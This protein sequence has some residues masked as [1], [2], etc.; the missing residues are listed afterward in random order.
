MS[1]L[2][3][4][5][6]KVAVVTGG[7][8]GI[9]RMMAEGF[10]QAGARTYITSRKAEE[11]QTSAEELSALGECVALQS[12]L[13]SLEGVRRFAREIR[14]RE[15]RLDILVNNA[16]ATWGE[17][18]EEYQESGWDKVMNINLKSLF[19]LTQQSLPILRASGCPEDPARVINIA[20]ING[21]A[22][23]GMP[24]YAYSASKAA[25]IHL[26][27]HLAADLVRDHINVNGIAPGFFPSKMTKGL[28]E[29]L[30]EKMLRRIPRGRLGEPG[31]IAG[32]A[33]YLSSR[34]SAWMVGQTLVLDGG[35][36]AA[37]G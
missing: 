32:T 23:P 2:F 18:L 37:S 3:S 15:D 35:M 36:V 24:V 19:F 10:L 29:A 17:P 16:G 25:V 22:N 7:S 14:E 9:G 13:S 30:D 26:T 11:L 27:R 5:A 20:S 8:R 21:I 28:L 1:E 12:D 34:A 33:I 31:D 4:I 6:G